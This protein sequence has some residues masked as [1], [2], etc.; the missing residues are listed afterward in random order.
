MNNVNGIEK[1]RLM[2]ILSM[3]FGILAVV[4]AF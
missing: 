2:G 1:S 4:L 3:V